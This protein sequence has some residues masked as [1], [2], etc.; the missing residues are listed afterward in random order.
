MHRYTYDRPLDK[1]AAHARLRD[2]FA[3]V[4]APEKVQTLDDLAPVIEFYHTPSAPG[5]MMRRLHSSAWHGRR[6]GRC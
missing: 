3:A 4:P 1:E 5:S 6:R 2:Y